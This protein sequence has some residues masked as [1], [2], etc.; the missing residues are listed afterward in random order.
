MEA[1]ESIDN[2]EEI[3]D[4]VDGA[5]VARGDLGAE[6]PFEHVPYWQSSIIQGCRY[7]MEWQRI[8]QQSLKNLLQFSSIL[9][10]GYILY[11]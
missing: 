1:A 8:E 5:M 10:E 2:L 4:A 9:L 6:L 7:S 3:L 11:C